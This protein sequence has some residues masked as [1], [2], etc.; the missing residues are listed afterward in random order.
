MKLSFMSDKYPE[1]IE[2]LRIKAKEMFRK[3]SM[4]RWI[5]FWLDSLAV[6]LVFLFAYLLRFNL[7]LNAFSM[8]LGIHHALIAAVVYSLSS[9]A[10]SS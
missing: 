4:P 9:L 6:F 10:F 5:V 2:F 1:W 8:N 7:E 3:H